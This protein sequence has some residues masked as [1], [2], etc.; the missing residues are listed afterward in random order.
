MLAELGL[1][2]N[3]FDNP[4]DALSHIDNNIIS[5]FS[6]IITDYKMP[7]MN[8]IEFIK[9]IREKYSSSNINFSLKLMLIS[10]FMKS[11]LDDH[12]ILNHL[13][14]DKIIEKPIPLDVFKLEVEKLM[15]QSSQISN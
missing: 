4:I 5:N 8:G 1:S 14:I 7:Q 12:D 13:K 11:D 15:K 10:A 2:N 6:L 9:K 3:F